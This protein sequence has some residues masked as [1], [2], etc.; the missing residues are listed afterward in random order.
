MSIPVIYPHVHPMLMSGIVFMSTQKL[1]SVVEFYTS[2]LGM[3]IWI[4]QVDCTILRRGDFALGFCQR[5][6]ADIGGIITFLCDTDKEVDD[7]YKGLKDCAEG[8]PCVVEKYRIYRF[9]LRD[10]EGRRLEIQRFVGI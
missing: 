9:F 1:S 3:R 10:P 6:R 8:E 4:E 2:R 5:E 7:W